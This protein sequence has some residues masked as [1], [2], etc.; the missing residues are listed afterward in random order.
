MTVVN[1]ETGAV[2]T[3]LPIG[4]GVDAVKYDPATHLVIC[5]NG[6]GTATVI[7]QKSPDEYAVI[8]TIATQYRAKT[9][10]IDLR[11][12]KIYFSCADFEADHR[13]EVPGTFKVLEYRL[14]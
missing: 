9:M 2:I 14:K 4:A 10:D 8:Q 5:S 1:A 13:H 11:T 6:D 7:R 12:H 3:T